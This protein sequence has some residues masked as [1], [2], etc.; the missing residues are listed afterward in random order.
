MKT[1]TKV[2]STDNPAAGPLALVVMAIGV[3][4]FLC[5]V[6]PGLPNSSSGDTSSD[7]IRM[8]NDITVPAGT[9]MMR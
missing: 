5:N 7:S 3:L 8:P 1:T 2:S 6:W 9:S 4:L